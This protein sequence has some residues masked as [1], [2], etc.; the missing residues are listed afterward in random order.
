VSWDR[1]PCPAQRPHPEGGVVSCTLA[2]GHTPVQGHKEG[3]WPHAPHR[4]LTK[5][6]SQWIR[7]KKKETDGSTR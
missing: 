5:S 3:A 2:E 7:P 1:P 6:P 4:L